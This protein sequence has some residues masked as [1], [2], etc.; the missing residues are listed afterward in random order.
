MGRFRALLVCV[1]WIL[2]GCAHGSTLFAFPPVGSDDANT[3]PVEETREEP[4]PSILRAPLRGHATPAEMRHVACALRPSLVVVGQPRGIDLH[5]AGVPCDLATAGA[6]QANIDLDHSVVELV[7]PDGATPAE[8]RELKQ[9]LD[10]IEAELSRRL[11][12]IPRPAPVSVAQVEPKKR[13]T[14]WFITSAALGVV[15]V[16]VLGVGGGMVA[17][18]DAGLRNTGTTMLTSI[19]LPLGV[20]ALITLAIAGILVVSE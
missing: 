11:A 13:S 10:D 7:V 6:L 3:T 4:V 16:C 18:S 1:A 9:G 17:S 14:K 2:A 5:I 15:G 20:G 8:A 19:A 12:S